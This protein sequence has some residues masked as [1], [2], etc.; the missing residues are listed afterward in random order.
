MVLQ[1]GIIIMV[2]MLYVSEFSNN[3]T[4]QWTANPTTKPTRPY[5]W[6]YPTAFSSMVVGFS[7]MDI[8][9]SLDYPAELQDIPTLTQCTWYPDYGGVMQSTG[10]YMIVFGF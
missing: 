10:F 8:N 3:F 6:T 1:M 4:I 9:K 2:F 5:T 7:W